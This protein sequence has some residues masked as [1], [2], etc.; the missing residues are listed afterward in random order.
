MVLQYNALAIEPGGLLQA[1]NC[2]V[3]RENIVEDRRGYYVYFALPGQGVQNFIYSNTAL[4]HNGTQITYDSSGTSA[5]YA[6]TYLAPA[7]R[8]IRACEAYQNLYFTTSKGIQVLTDVAGT[9]ARLAGSPR[10]LDIVPQASV[11]SAAGALPQGNQCAY[12]TV[13]KRTDANQNVIFSY[14][15]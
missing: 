15:Q 10:P 7:G 11:N 2:V 14:P 1:D 12:R 8:K 4:T 9:Q 6:G 5:N 13:I 3:D